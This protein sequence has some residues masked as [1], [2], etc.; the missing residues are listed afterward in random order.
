[1]V[2]TKKLHEAINNL[3]QAIK[4]YKGDKTSLNFLTVAKAF[5]VVIEYSWRELK[6]TV[7]DEGLEAVSPK[8]AIKQAAKMGL[9]E[10]PETWIECINARNDSVH[11]Y[12]GIPNDRY[13][14]LATSL[15]KLTAKMV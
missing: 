14:E 4:Q 12:F 13:L 7:E 6:R 3:D 9:V 1:M 10:D 8:M 5:E 2:S 15:L 11:D